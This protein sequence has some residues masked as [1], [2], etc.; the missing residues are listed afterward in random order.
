MTS[1]APPMTPNSTGADAAGYGGGSPAKS[2]L[3]AAATVEA[4]QAANPHAMRWCS[5]RRAPDGSS[6][7]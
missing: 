7:G 2:W 4:A 6:P 1:P 3:I 5:R